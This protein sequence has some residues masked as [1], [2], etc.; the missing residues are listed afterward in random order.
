MITDHLLTG[1]LLLTVPGILFLLAGS[2][3]RVLILVFSM[4]IVFT[5]G[6]LKAMQISIFRPDDLLLLLL[7]L[8][9]LISLPDMSMKGI[10][11]GV[12]GIF[13]TC[14]LILISIAALRGISAGRSSISLID[15]IKTFGGYFFYFPL[16]WIL[17]DKDNSKWLWRAFLVST[18]IGSLI[19]TI[20]GYIGYGENV[21]I[22]KT[23]GIRVATRQPNA[24]AV[25]MLMFIGRLW[26]DWK[27]RPAIIF[28]VPSLV[29]MGSAIILSQT[30]GIWGGILLALSS[31]WILNLFRK[32]DG[33]AIG[34][35]LVASLTVLAGLVILT[36]F[37]VSALGIVSTSNIIR[38]TG[39][40]SGSYITDVSTFSRIVAWS[41]II[42]ELRGSSMIVGKGLGAVY[43]CYRP[44]IGSVVTVYYVDSSYFL[45][46]LDMGI[47]GVL[48]LLGIFIT[49]AVRA[50]RLFVRTDNQLRAGI[51]IGIF[52]AVI[53][54]L[55]ASGFAAV[56]T[57][58]RYTVLWVF[59]PA[60]LQS[61]IIRE[62]KCQI[63]AAVN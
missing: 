48:I 53:M 1:V 51:S 62:E 2:P 27:N 60:L 12:Q 11:I 49:T 35:K 5:I 46:A 14:F 29:L 36:V 32:K 7:L 58:Y 42:E 50:A 57:S 19:Y 10:K 17:S 41:A 40:E 39:S 33:K 55:F 13:I 34:R 56:L 25:V 59:L 21:F 18:I 8:L 52:C 31:A 3:V 28:I 44:D 15:Q 22:R 43:T 61:E 4:H 6:Q 30:R 20:K 16:L 45:V 54:L 38:R 26:K 9:W 23:T 24:F 63:P 37:S 47:I